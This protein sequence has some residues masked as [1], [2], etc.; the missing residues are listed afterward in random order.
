MCIVTFYVS[1]LPY[2][3]FFPWNLPGVL[4]PAGLGMALGFSVLAAVAWRA[5]VEIR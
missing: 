5:E 3:S 4:W 1:L 2:P